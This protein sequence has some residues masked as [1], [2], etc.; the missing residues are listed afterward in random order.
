[1]AHEILGER[2]IG[3]SKPAWHNLG[4]VFGEGEQLLASEAAR[5]IA[6]DIQVRPRELYY[7]DQDGLLVKVDGHQAIVRSP[8]PD[9]PKEKIF[10]ITTEKWH[11]VAYPDLAGA[12]D[13]LSKKYK[14]ETCGLIQDGSL[15][16]LSLRGPD[17]SVKGDQMQDYFIANLS[18][19]PG[20][21]HKV[22]ASPVRVVCFNT[23]MAADSRA[24]I[25]LRVTHS[26]G[27][28]EKIKLAADLVAKFKEMTGK[29]RET[30]ESFAETPVTAEGLEAILNAA[31]PD[32]RIPAELRLLQTAVGN[33]QEQGALKEALG[34]QFNRILKAQETYDKAKD[35]TVVLRTASKERFE[36]FE[37]RNQRGTV[38]AA[39]NA[40]TEVSDWR[41]GR[42]ADEGTVWGGRAREKAHA[43]TAATALV[44]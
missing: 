22:L 15:M 24:S 31:F 10:G 6:G 44:N 39:Y 36:L 25:N 26:A 43:F 21:S 28:K 13:E 1:M 20:N 42:N 40:A 14:V 37:P 34:T 29:M 41:E 18:N 30:F 32:P 27:A 19:Q 8:L 9:D 7:R 11:P 38:W 17:F 3:R 12:L 16:F 35:R 2:F 5:R 4:T 33:S 23:N